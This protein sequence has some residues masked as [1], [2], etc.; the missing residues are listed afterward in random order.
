MKVYVVLYTDR[1]DECQHQYITGV[2]STKELAQQKIDD[3]IENIYLKHLV[4]KEKERSVY[5]RLHEIE[6]IE[7]DA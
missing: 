1:W 3:Q 4:D 7:V 2:F 6:E 5:Q